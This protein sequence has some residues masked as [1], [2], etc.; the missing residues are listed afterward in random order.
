MLPLVAYHVF[1]SQPCCAVPHAEFGWFQVAA[2]N[3]VRSQRV[4]HAYFMGMC[5]VL[6]GITTDPNVAAVNDYFGY[7]AHT[8][9]VL[10]CMDRRR[11]HAKPMCRV[12][13]GE[14]RAACVTRHCAR[15]KGHLHEW[16]PRSVAVG[17]G[18]HL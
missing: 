16:R 7:G 18:S 5:D 10:P 11:S 17:N 6:F 3:G 2:T 4:D 15:F 8:K 13:D 12:C 14:W 1:T 9:L